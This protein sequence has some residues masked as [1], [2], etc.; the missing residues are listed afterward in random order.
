MIL[1]IQMTRLLPDVFYANKY[2]PWLREKYGDAWDNE[3]DKA[4]AAKKEAQVQ[5]K[6]AKMQHGSSVTGHT[7]D[8]PSYKKFK[9]KGN[10]AKDKLRSDT[11]SKGVKFYDKKGTGRIRDGKKHYD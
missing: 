9:E 5:F 2:Q 3:Q 4:K 1:G 11:I 8:S 10:V 7:I 6:R